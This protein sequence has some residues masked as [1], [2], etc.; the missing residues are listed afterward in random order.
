MKLYHFFLISFI[1]F[2]ACTMNSESNNLQSE[3]AKIETLHQQD[4]KASK[5]GDYKTLRSLLSKDAVMMPP[6]SDWIQGEVQ[7]EQNYL[8]M[9]EAMKGIEIL[10]YQLNFEEV[11]ILGD[12]AFEWGEIIGSSR[13]KDGEITESIYKVMRI[14]KKND[15]GEWK[16]HRAIWNSNPLE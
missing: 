9:E 5:K 7:L 15:N 14:L 16:V 6:N 1:L 11:K 4:M 2:N 10:D 3:L 13:N 12:Y 8:Q